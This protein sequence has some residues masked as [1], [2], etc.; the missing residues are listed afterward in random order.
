MHGRSYDRPQAQYSCYDGVSTEYIGEE[1]VST[2]LL[3]ASTQ[4]WRQYDEVLVV[5]AV[6]Y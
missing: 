3:E 2:L 5:Y 1:E 6:E 4:P